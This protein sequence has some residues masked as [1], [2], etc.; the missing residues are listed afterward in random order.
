MYDL[1]V[2]S[3][4]CRPMAKCGKKKMGSSDFGYTGY[5][6]KQLGVMREL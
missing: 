5:I 3:M 1:N 4:N 2:W 6:L